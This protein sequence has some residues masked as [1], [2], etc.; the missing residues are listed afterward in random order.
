MTNN[1]KFYMDESKRAAKTALFNIYMPK[2][3]SI[4][5]TTAKAVQ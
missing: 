5:V 2:L 4:M 3:R 1:P